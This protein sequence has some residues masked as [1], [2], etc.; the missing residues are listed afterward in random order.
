M[1]TKSDAIKALKTLDGIIDS[2]DWNG[3]F[4]DNELN[5]VEKSMATIKQFIEQ[6]EK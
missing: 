6:E 4:N 3:V 5:D 1:V 2:L